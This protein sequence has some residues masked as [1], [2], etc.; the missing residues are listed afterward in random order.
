[1]ESKYRYPAVWILAASF[2]ASIITLIIYYLE[3][4]FSDESLL[5]MLSILR[6]TSFLV[7]IS[8][9]FLVITGII[10]VIKKPSVVSVITLILPLFAAIYGV[11]IIIIGIFILA[12]MGGS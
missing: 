9:L 2:T 4:D 7:F 8:S 3:I 10:R 12:F 11:C 5:F 6:Y 1:M